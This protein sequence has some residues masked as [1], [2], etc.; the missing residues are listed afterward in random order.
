MQRF[1]T[2]TIRTHQIGKEVL[3]Q[4]WRKVIEMLLSQHPEV[5]R[6]AGLRKQ[7]IVDL[8]FQKGDIES[9]IDLLD[10]RDR[11]EKAILIFLKRQPYSYYN[12]FT[13]ISR[14]TRFIYVHG[15]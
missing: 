10:R 7:Q 6:E 14:N 12:A 1:G 2:Y 15:Y 13:N 9:A 11:L 4:N 8:V 3:N 5:D